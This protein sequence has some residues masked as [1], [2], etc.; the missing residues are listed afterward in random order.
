[1]KTVERKKKVSFFRYEIQR[2]IREIRTDLGLTQNQ[3]AKKMTD[4]VNQSTI[5][6]WESGKTEIGAVQLMDLLALADKEI[7]DL[8]IKK[9]KDKI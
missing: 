8:K 7:T 4:D 1:M 2:M 9:E 5:S 3:L 6:N